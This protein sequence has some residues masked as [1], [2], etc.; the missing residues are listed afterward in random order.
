MLLGGAI[1]ITLGML[2]GYFGGGLDRFLTRLMD[3]QLSFPPVFLAIAIIA[4]MG[5]N[6]TNMIIVLGLVTLVL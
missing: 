5:Q 6:L 4:T 1:G 2:A 3:I